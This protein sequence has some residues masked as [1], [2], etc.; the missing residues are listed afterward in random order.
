[1][2]PIRWAFSMTMAGG[3]TFGLFYF[4][5]SLIATG[6]HFLFRYLLEDLGMT[7]IMTGTVTT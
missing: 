2:I 4:M 1:M 6:A 5:Q 3:I 7:E